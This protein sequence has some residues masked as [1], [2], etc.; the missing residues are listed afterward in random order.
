MC[1]TQNNVRIISLQKHQADVHEITRTADI[2][3][4]VATFTLKIKILSIGMGITFA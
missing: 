3:E 1:E 2:P 4:M